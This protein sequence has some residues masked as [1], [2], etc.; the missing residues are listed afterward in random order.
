[1]SPPVGRPV[2]GVLQEGVSS[3]R[4]YLLGVTPGRGLLR[5]A[6]LLVRYSKKGSPPVGGPVRGYSRKGSPP[7]GGPVRGYSRKGSPPVGRTC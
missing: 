7:T 4:R 6:D 1:M 5:S 3:N 2:R